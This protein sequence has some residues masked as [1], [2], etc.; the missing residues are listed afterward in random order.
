MRLEFRAG[1][2]RNKVL[3]RGSEFWGGFE[4]CSAHTGRQFP[5]VLH[6]LIRDSIIRRICYRPL[7]LSLTI[8]RLGDR[9]FNLGGWRER[10]GRKRPIS[11]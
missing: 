6:R 7:F 5:V 2:K 4:L 11:F 3:G 8:W 1:W 9:S 10:E